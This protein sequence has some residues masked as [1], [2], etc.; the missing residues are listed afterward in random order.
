MTNPK[1]WPLRLIAGFT[2]VFLLIM[3]KGCYDRINA[4]ITVQASVDKILDDTLQME[5]GRIPDPGRDSTDQDGNRFRI[6]EGH[7][8]AAYLRRLRIWLVDTPGYAWKLSNWR[9]DSL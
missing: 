4:P 6:Y 5:Q 1:K 9:R 2:I 7:I 8:V 3:A